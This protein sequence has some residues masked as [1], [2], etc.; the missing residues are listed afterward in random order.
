MDIGYDAYLRKQVDDFFN[1]RTVED[2]EKTQDIQEDQF[3][4]FNENRA[5]I[6]EE[7]LWS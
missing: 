6:D 2:E 4:W 3:D 1:G 7:I 5:E